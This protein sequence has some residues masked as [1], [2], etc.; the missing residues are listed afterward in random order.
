MLKNIIF[1]RICAGL[2][3]GLCAFSMLGTTLSGV[4]TADAASE[5]A[6]PS[7]DKVIAQAAQLLGTKYTFGAKGG[8]PYAN[9]YTLKNE[10][11]T[12]A[13]GIDCSGLIWWTLTNLGYKTSGFGQNNPVPADTFGWLGSTGTKTITYGGVTANIEIEKANLPTPADKTAKKTYEYWECAD[14]STILPGSV[15]VAQNP[16]GE[17]H[18]WIYMGEFNSRAEVVSYLKSI[19]VPASKITTATVGDGKGNAGKHWRIESNGSEGVVINNKSDGKTVSAMNMFA[20]RVTPRNVTFE[21][22]KLDPDGNLVGTS[23]VDGS[24]AVYGIYSDKACKNKVTELTIGANGRGSVSVPS[25]TYYAKE[26]K[27]PKGYELDTRIHTITPG[28][29]TVTEDFD[30]GKIIINKTAEDGVIGGREFKVSWTDNG[31]PNSMTAKTN[32]KGVAEFPDLK[33][34]D[35]ST[36]KAIKYTVSEI[37]VETRYETPKAQNVYL[38][39]GDKDFT[40]TTKFENNNKTGNIKIN[41]Q[42]DDGKNG[43]RLFTVVGNGRVYNR[44]TDSS[45]IAEFK[46]LP[47]YDKN[48]KKITYTIMEQN[49][50]LRYVVPANQTTTLTVDATVNKTF[51]NKLKV[52]N[53]LINKQAEDGQVGDRTFVITGNGKSYTVKTNDNGVAELKNIPVYDSNDNKITYTVSEKD[54]PIRYAVPAAQ[55]A[56]LTADLTVTKTFNNLL[57]K[58]HIKVNKQAEDGEIADRKFTVT[59]NGKTWTKYTNNEGVAEFRDLPVYDSNNNKITYR[60]SEKDVPIKYAAPA[61]QK[62]TL[63][64]DATV[65]KTFVNKLASTSIQ[66]FKEA[67]DDVIEGIKFKITGG[68]KT[69]NVVTDANGYAELNDIKAYDSDGKAITYT[70]SETD[71]PLRYIVPAEQTT[72]VTV[73]RA[74]VIKFDNQPKT[75][76]IKINKQAEDGEKGGRTFKVTGNGKTYSA[77]TDKNGIAEFKDLP[78]YDVINKPIEYT[79]SEKNVPLRYVVPA[80]QKTT[81]SVDATVTKTFKNDLK[82]GG[83]KINKQSDDGQNGGR[84]FTVTGNGKT[85]TAKTDKNGIAEFSE[86]PVYDSEDKA[87]EYTISE[88]EVPIRYVVPADQKT[89][90]IADETTTKTFNNESKKGTILINKQAEDGIIGDR[91]FEVSGNGKSYTA[92]TNK[93]GIAEFKELPVYD[94]NDKPIEYTISEKNVPLKYVVPAAQTTTLT[95]DETVKKTFDNNIKKGYISI[96]KHSDSDENV[97]ENMEEGAEFQVYNKAYE[98]YDVTPEDERDYLITD[99]NGYDKTVELPYGTYVVHQTKTVKDAEYA[100]DFEVEVTENEKTYEYVI[101]NAPLQ[102][103]IKVTKVDAETGKTVA[104]SGAGFEI[105]RADKTQV[106]MT[107]EGKDYSTFYTDNNGI[108]M[109]PATLGYGKYTLVEVQAPEGYVLDSTPVSFKVTRSNSTV[110]NA[111]N[112]VMLTKKDAPQKGTITVEK[113]G[114]MFFGFDKEF[115]NAQLS[116]AE[117]E[118]R[119][120][121]D[122]VTA[123]GTKRAFAGDIVATIITGEDGTATTEPLYLGKYTV[124]ETKAPYGYVMNSKKKAVEL[125]YAGQDVAVTD[126][127]KTKFRNEYQSVS[128]TLK[129]YMEH[130]ELFGIGGKGEYKAVRFGLFT[131]DE[132]RTADG[133][134]VPKDYLVSELALSEDM[135]A[136]FDRKIPFGKYYVQEISTDEHYVLNGEKYPVT[137]TYAG[138]EIKTVEIDCGTFDNTIKRG[139][140][141]GLKVNLSDEPL[142]NALFGLFKANEKKFTEARALMTATS[143]SKGNFAFDGIAYGKYVVREIKAPDGY[144]LSDKKYDVNISENEQ[145]IEIKAENESIDVDVSKQDVYGKELPGAK[146]QLLDKDGNVIDKWKSTKKKHTVTNLK[147]GDYVLKETAAPTGYVIAT[148]ISFSVDEYGVVTVNG[149]EATASDDSGNPTIVMVDDTTKTSITKKDISGDKEVE[150]AEMKLFDKDGNIVEEWT[151]T[152]K[153]HEITGKLKAGDKYTLH[154]ESAPDGYVVAADIEFTV[155]ETGEIDAVTMKDDTTKVHITK[156]DITGEKEIEG[157]KLQLIDENGNIVDEWVS[158]SEAHIIEG[159]LIAGKEYTLHEEICPDG[160][161]VANDITFKVSENGDVDIVN[162]KDDTTKV[163]ISKKDITAQNEL[164]G[165]TLQIIDENGNVVEEWV[166]TNEPHYVEGKL[167]AGKTYTLREITAPDGYE[168]ANDVK[169]TVDEKGNITQVVMYDEHT[170]TT[171]PPS[172]PPKTGAERSESGMA[173]ALA[174]LA[175][176][177]ILLVAI[178]KKE[179]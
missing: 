49:V 10:A 117:F 98:S 140:V 7:A 179:K 154:E 144:K 94:V 83:I 103:F 57:Q 19:G 44:S 2:L 11:Q 129:K 113:V 108:V 89:T 100:A 131:D 163:R 51:K 171:P 69:Y 79:I 42:S 174:A 118:I 62:T 72:T 148:D 125:T 32:S 52:G 38:T 138:Q 78:V 77:K 114:E 81:L 70:V 73:N 37:N 61:D 145:I 95:V 110:E 74:S 142:E 119:A 84:T 66:I 59:G 143:D 106:V 5:P 121:E 137:Y 127:A 24:K 158:I 105:Y 60:I 28:T 147:A 167:I 109:T 26:L 45:G 115:E 151:S 161:V 41:K 71:V 107:V 23:K 135:T 159:K 160:Y 136:T 152:D 35:L 36:G 126:D 176:G 33:I 76:N 20:Y 16:Y 112:V 18:S 111:V 120:A 34:Y 124:Q 93:K 40:V 4:V 157:A 172:T 46:D 150:G 141:K 6:F 3:S 82:K 68:G 50:P 156:T 21:L 130:D 175:I 86:L 162:M 64:V 17:D 90:L 153:A 96:I 30:Y 155:S 54:V 58:G 128:I 13:Q 166:S 104:L 27:A 132:I 8:N 146:M 139:S 91:T 88:E 101:N 65:T 43:S 122:I 80:D 48:N 15:V 149:V 134:V 39:N 85:Y 63:T 116:G 178:R 168:I 53:I 56:T 87:I 102:A 97:V 25:G 92:V 9:P 1:K 173:C 12:R 47:V 29:T 31:K 165:A 55:T 75:G 123:D 14:G 170:P 169:F 133:N 164:P 22:K 67:E 99:K 177:A